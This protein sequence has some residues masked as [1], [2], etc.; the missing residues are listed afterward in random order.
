MM[1]DLEEMYLD[2]EEIL[3]NSTTKPLE[4]V[5]D[6]M[7]KEEVYILNRLKT[8]MVITKPFKDN[9]VTSLQRKKIVEY[10]DFIKSKL[11]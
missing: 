6:Y 11:N 5:V 10:Y 2:F 3:M 7:K 8:L 9:P 4:G 1:K